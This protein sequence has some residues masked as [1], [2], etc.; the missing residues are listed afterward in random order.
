MTVQDSDYDY[1]LQRQAGKTA[2]NGR[3]LR[4]FLFKIIRSLAKQIPGIGMSLRRK[5]E[6]VGFRIGVPVDQTTRAA[7]AQIQ[8]IARKSPAAGAPTI[9]TQ[10]ASG[11]HPQR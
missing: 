11:T 6:N 5:V 10:A 2:A 7:L 4:R 9:G 3:T 8:V 1:G